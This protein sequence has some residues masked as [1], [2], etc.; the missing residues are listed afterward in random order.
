MSE[1][2]F[3]SSKARDEGHVLLLFAPQL[4]DMPRTNGVELFWESE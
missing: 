3:R 1:C 2:Q 4:A